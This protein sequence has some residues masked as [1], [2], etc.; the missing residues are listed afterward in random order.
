MSSAEAIANVVSDIANGRFD[1]YFEV[2]NIVV[3]HAQYLAKHSPVVD[4]TAIFHKHTVGKAKYNFYEDYNPVLLPWYMFTLA[5]QNS[6]ENV[7]VLQVLGLEKGES[8]SDASMWETEHITDWDSQCAYAFDAI[9]WSG[10]KS[11]GRV[12]KTAGPIQM[13]QIA[14]DKEGTVLDVHWV[15]FLGGHDPKQSE[16]LREVGMYDACLLTLFESLRFLTC[17]NVDIVEPKRERHERRRIERTG[18]RVYNLTVF[19][20][21]KSYRSSGP[22]D[23]GAGVPLTSVRGHFA[24]YGPEYGK[25]L[26]FGKYEGK[27]WIPQ[28]ARGSEEHGE[29]HHNYTLDTSDKIS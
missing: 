8:W 7:H 10:G 21:G 29:S 3:E 17:R 26:L 18:I 1:T 5:W 20:I 6:Y 2:N 27:F 9:L 28:H 24:H 13:F 11:R 19:P 14:T 15:D 4:A 12:Q 22:V 25:K 23:R 16:F